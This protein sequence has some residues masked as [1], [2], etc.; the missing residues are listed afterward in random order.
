M[1]LELAR[2]TAHE[3]YKL[4]IGLGPEMEARKI[5]IRWPSGIVS[6]VE[7]LA[8]DATYELVEPQLPPTKRLSP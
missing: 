8:A 5:T 7:R 3:R 4:L 2:L 6:T 1:D